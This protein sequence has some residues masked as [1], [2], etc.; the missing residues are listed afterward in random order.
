MS[1]QIPQ[2]IIDSG[3]SVPIQTEP[4]IHCPNCKTQNQTN[5]ERCQ[6]CGK[7]LLPD[8]GTGL[9]L[10]FLF[11]FLILAGMF[12]YL[13]YWNFIREGAP[14]PESFWL[15]PVSLSVGILVSLILAFV[16][17]LR[18]IPKYKRYE[19][20]SSR[21]LNLDIYQSIADLTSA[22]EL[23]PENVQHSLLKQ[24]RSLFEKIGDSTNADR[25]RL[26]LALHPDAWKSEGDFLS[27]F[28]GLEGDAF[29]WSMRRS[30]IDTLRSSGVAVAVGYCPACKTVVELDKDMNCTVHPKI[31][32]RDEQ[33][34][35]PEDIAAGK[36][37]V[38]A[39]LERKKAHLAGEI[40][41]MLE[42]KE[43]IAVAYC[44]R[45]QSVVQLDAQR[46]CLDHPNE[47]I[48]GVAYALPGNFDARKRQ[49]LHEQ[50]LK[51]VNNTRNM[52]VLILALA[53]LAMVYFVFLK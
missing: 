12:V 29:S 19:I 46:C 51:M 23:A 36:L 41:K 52:V 3:A 11:F 39:K 30:A 28:G 31:K 43:V 50:H 42:A 49:M 4:R 37:A 1:T 35:I 22:L 26:A 24:R 16:L 47:K 10:F 45:C 33:L 2:K 25:D 8:Q 32:G 53:L 38:M 13:M 44:P 5:S 6:Q 40:T 9:R 48:K 27:V 21:H 17:A 14:N 7:D 34:V 20:R 18:R 15:N